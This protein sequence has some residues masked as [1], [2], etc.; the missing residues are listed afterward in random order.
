MCY[1]IH[2]IIFLLH[3]IDIVKKTKKK[4]SSEIKNHLHFY[5][6]NNH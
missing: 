2:I 3:E 1:C 6:E 4:S 5:I